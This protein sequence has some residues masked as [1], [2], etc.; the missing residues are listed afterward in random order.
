[1]TVQA[2]GTNR[3][4]TM[5]FLNSED[6]FKSER[7]FTVVLDLMALTKALEEAKVTDP[8][9]H[10]KGKTVKVKGVVSLFKDQPQII[11]KKLEQITVVGD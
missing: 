4:K 2:T 3:T 5:V 8:L 7:N 11:V 9:R 10:Y 1:M 6:D